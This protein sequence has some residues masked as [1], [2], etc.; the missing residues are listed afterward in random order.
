[1]MKCTNPPSSRSRKTRTA[2]GANPPNSNTNAARNAKPDSGSFFYPDPAQAKGLAF[3]LK[4]R[5]KSAA[6]AFSDLG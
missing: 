2:S 1:M 4:K 6:A 5:R 3:S